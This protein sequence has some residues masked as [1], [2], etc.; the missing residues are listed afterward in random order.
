MLEFIKKYDNVL[1]DDLCD[2]IIEEFNRLKDIG[3]TSKGNTGSGVNL[4]FKDANDLNIFRFSNKWKNKYINDYLDITWNNLFKY[5]ANWPYQTFTNP[6]KDK[7]GKTFYID[8]LKDVSKFYNSEQ[9]YDLFRRNHKLQSSANTKNIKDIFPDDELPVNLLHHYEKNT[10]GYHI[11]HNDG[12]PTNI[13]SY[14][15]IIIYM[16][17]LNDV[18]KGGET[19]FPLL[20]YKVKPKKGTMLIWPACWPTHHK[21]H[22]PISNDKYI[23]TGWVTTCMNTFNSMNPTAVWRENKMKGIH[24][25]N[26]L[27]HFE[28]TQIKEDYVSKY[29]HRKTKAG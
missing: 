7:N 6:I 10:G 26:N 9:L 11:V 17:Y 15:R 5:W 13:S 22:I 24:P 16:Y 19:D 28:K 20:D 14:G 29:L 23:V 3:L 8:N 25:K 4:Q 27:A 1:S 21:G 2:S 12:T 18:T